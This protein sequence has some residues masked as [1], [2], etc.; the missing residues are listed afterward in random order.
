MYLVPEGK[1]A[2]VT[3]ILIF[4]CEVLMRFEIFAMAFQLQKMF[5]T[6]EKQ[7]SNHVVGGS[8]HRRLLLTTL[9]RTVVLL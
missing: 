6:F 4:F 9:K 7:V 2:K 1:T 8:F 3:S 5:E